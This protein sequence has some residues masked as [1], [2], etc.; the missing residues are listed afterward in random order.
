MQIKGII[1]KLDYDKME[2]VWQLKDGGDFTGDVEYPP[3]QH[4]LHVMDCP[5]YD[6]CLLTYVNG[7]DTDKTTYARQIGI[8]E[9]TMEATIVR[10][11]TE[12]GWEEPKIGGIDPFGDDGNRWL[13]A[14]GHFTAQPFNDRPSQLVELAPDDTVDWR[15]T[16][17]T[18]DIQVYRARRVAACDV[19]HHAGY[20]PSLEK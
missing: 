3:W 9:T 5:G 19:F 7:V 18:T 2:I 20:C 1:Y 4:D 17:A 8:D 13:I 12:D 6:E 14:E 15:L 10:E 11:W 16:V